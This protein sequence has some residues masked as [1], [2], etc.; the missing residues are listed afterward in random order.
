M[1]G[2]EMRGNNTTLRA[3]ECIECMSELHCCSKRSPVRVGSCRLTTRDNRVSAT[4]VKGQCTCEPCSDSST[5]IFF[6]QIGRCSNISGQLLA[7]HRHQWWKSCITTNALPC[8]LLPRWSRTST[9]PSLFSRRYCSFSDIGVA[10]AL[11]WL[12]WDLVR[13]RWAF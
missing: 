13:S 3:C 9:A 5:V 4:S 11:I 10:M 2:G 8:Q 12:S 7:A 1:W 6:S